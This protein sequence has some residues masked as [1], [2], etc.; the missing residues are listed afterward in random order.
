VGKG[1]VTVVTGLGVAAAF[2]ARHGDLLWLFRYDRRPSRER[3]RLM[4]FGEETM[5]HARSGWMREP[6][7]IAGDTVYFAPLDSDELFACWLRGA[8]PAGHGFE[9]E[10]WSKDRAKGHRHSLLEYVGGL[11]AGRIFYVGRCDPRPALSVT[12][13]AV[14]SH[15]LDRTAGLAYGLLPHAERAEGTGLAMPP[16]IYGN[17]VIA[18][19]VL[20]VPT[21]RAIYRFDAA[22]EPARSMRDGEQVREIGVLPPYLAPDAID[23]SEAAFGALMA[24][25]GFLFATTTDR[26]LC[27]GEAR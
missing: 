10:Q 11:S 5:V 17:P 14:V 13:Q 22:R 16:E 8:R 19:D 18:G 6:P 2:E 26:I 4:E 7:R 3:E 24:V 25:D 23:D 20:L 9:I 21:R 12:Y 27:Y 1:V 15:P